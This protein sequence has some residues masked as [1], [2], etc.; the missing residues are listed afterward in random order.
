MVRS[1]CHSQAAGPRWPLHG[2][3]NAWS[4]L[5]GDVSMEWAVLKE[6]DALLAPSHQLLSRK[7]PCTAAQQ[8]VAVLLGEGMPGLA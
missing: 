4:A 1:L 3:P 8:A 2:M 6:H 5:D 7:Q